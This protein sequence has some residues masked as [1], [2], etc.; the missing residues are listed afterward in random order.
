[1]RSIR[2]LCVKYELAM[3]SLLL[4][5]SGLLMLGLTGCTPREAP[6]FARVEHGRFVGANGA[7][8]YFVGANFWY[9]ALL[10][11]EGPNGN[12]DRLCHELDRLH[13]LG[14]DNLRILVGSEGSEG[15]VSKVE[16]ILQTAPG[17]YDDR[18]LDGL[19]FL[20]AEMGR[21]R[22][23]AVLYLT[24]AWEW[25]GGYSQYL[26]WSGHGTYPTPGQDGWD[27]FMRY[28]RRFHEAGP[29][30]SCKI[31]FENH[32]RHIVGRTNRY[33]NRPYSE[34]PAIFSWQIANEPRA[35]SEANKERFFEW[36]SRTAKLIKQLDPN[37]MIS[38]GSEGAMGCENDIELWR[39]IHALPEIDYA[40]IHI[41]AY[42]WGWIDRDSITENLEQACDK[43]AEYIGRHAEIARA[44]QKPL[45]IEEFGYPRDG[46]S[47]DPKAPVTARDTYYGHLFAQVVRSA[48]HGDILAGCNFWGWGGQARPA[49]LRWESGDDYCGDP[50][51]EE[52]GLNSVFDCD[53]STL[54]EITQTN[55]AL[56][57]YTRAATAKPGNKTPEQLLTQLRD[58]SAHG[59]LLFGQQDFPFYGCDWAYEEGRSDVKDLCGDHPAV[60]GCDL[61]EIELA[62]DR[63]LD[64]VPFDTMRAEILRQHARGG[65]T[66]ISWHPRNPLTG[67]DAWDVTSNQVV[68]SVLPGGTCHER[69]LGWLDR[70]ADFLLSL[71]ADDGSVIPILFRPW[72]EHTGSWFW[73]GQRLCTVE[74]YKELWK[75]TVDRLRLHGVPL[76]TVYSPN[77]CDGEAQYMERYPG[78][79][80]V[81]VL[82]LDAY[83]GGTSDEFVS[84]LG[85]ALAIMDSL[86][87]RLAKPY[88]LSETGR[89]GLPETNWWTGV[90][91]RGIGAYSPAYV[92]VWRNA[93]QAIKPGHFYAP[94]PGQASADD[95]M[96]FH[97]LPSTRFAT[98]RAQTTKR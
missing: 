49:H 13:A 98:E 51:Q 7:P 46:F 30:D 85:N 97:A 89:E 80:W 73:W 15:V 54:R 1:M 22:M 24:N 91:L 6:E 88:V 82:G 21:R 32:V 60:L 41:W 20:L 39:R 8:G 3:K 79:A 28:V 61:G 31:L 43:M 65:L 75:M 53:T 95:F 37:H 2:Y 11:V 44:L 50:A 63:N 5:I 96:R 12:R 27:A 23:Q 59:T 9:G 25:S 84:R 92:L 69:F 58:V 74:E 81:D 72:H 38:T 83:H 93:H 45:V 19:D 42:N 66:T 71:R 94:F 67:G 40:N 10:A 87:E 14:V 16:P 70:V 34:D 4:P 90:L 35:F 33:T 17:V 18:I 36:I 47:F 77:P 57:R 48:A 29:A 76:L 62:T 55:L 68:R 86:S 78:D 52:Q 64:G 26:E 56:T